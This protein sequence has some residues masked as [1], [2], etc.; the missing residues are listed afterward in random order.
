MVLHDEGGLP[1]NAPIIRP[2]LGA[3]CPK[4]SNLQGSQAERAQAHVPFKT[5]QG[6]TSGFFP[7][8]TEHPSARLAAVKGVMRRRLWRRSGHYSFSLSSASCCARFL[9]DASNMIE[10]DQPHGMTQTP[11]LGDFSGMGFDHPD[12]PDPSTA[13][14]GLTSP[15]GRGLKNIFFWEKRKSGRLRRVL[16]LIVLQN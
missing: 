4:S 15:G 12:H 9:L 7:D 1:A 11:R 5:Q 16:P 14:L 10:L 3:L 8:S 13:C 2:I 6:L